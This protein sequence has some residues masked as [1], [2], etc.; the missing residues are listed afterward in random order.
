MS[1]PTQ[2][3]SGP[4]RPDKREQTQEQMDDVGSF[5]MNILPYIINM[6]PIMNVFNENK[7]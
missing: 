4:L 7:T 6:A 3:M 1:I 5:N 2:V